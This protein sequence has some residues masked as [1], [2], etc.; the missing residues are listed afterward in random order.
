MNTKENNYGLY[1]GMEL[2]AEVINEWQYVG[3]NTYSKYKPIWH[4]WSIFE[5][6]TPFVG[7]RK[8]ES[9]EEVNGVSGFLVSDTLS[10]YLRAEGFKEF[11]ES[12][13]GGKEWYAENNTVYNSKDDNIR[14]A[15]IN[16]GS[17]M[18]LPKGAAEK[19]ADVLN[20]SKTEGNN[21]NI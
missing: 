6:Y 19:I 14:V 8:I 5:Y 9:I 18:S 20:N 17:Y 7:D 11:L 3:L 1:I 4:K 21:E 2:P 12:K 10:T 13:I 15:I 16:Q